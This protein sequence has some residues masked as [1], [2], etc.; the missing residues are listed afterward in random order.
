M[1]RPA[2]S[3]KQ[4][5][6]RTSEGSYSIQQI[7]YRTNKALIPP[8]RLPMEP[9]RALVSIQQND[10]RTNKFTQHIAYRTRMA[11]KCQTIGAAVHVIVLVC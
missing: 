8:S 11:L 7:A 2:H 9:M 3:V 1:V 4:I 10:Y 6:Y 5:A